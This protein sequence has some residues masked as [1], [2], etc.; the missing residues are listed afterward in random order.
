MAVLVKTAATLQVA[1]EST[2]GTFVAP[3]TTDS[4]LVEDPDF[5]VDLTTLERNFVR[6]SIS[7]TAIINGRKIARMKFSME[8]RSNGKNTGLLADAPLISRLFRACGFALTASATATAKIFQVGDHANPA[9]ALAVSAASATNTT[10]IMYVLRCTVG[11]ASATAQIQV[12]SDTAGESMA[13]ATITSGTP[14]T[15]GT[16][17]ATATI[18]FSGSLV[19][20][21]EWVVYLFP[22]GL[23]LNPISANFESVSLLMNKGGVQHQMPGCYGTFDI[24]AEAG[25][26]AK[27]NFDF[28]GI[29]VAPTDVAV[30]T[31]LTYETTLPAMVELAQLRVDDFNAI[32]SKY[33]LDIANEI[34]PRPDVSSAN[35]YIGLRLVDRKPEGG[36]D[37]EA[38]LVAQHDF[39]GKLSA[40]TR[41][42]FTIRCGTVVG[43]I[44]TIIHPQVQ[45]SGLTY[46]DRNN[47]LNYD[48]GLRIS[49]AAGDDE[50]LIF[51]G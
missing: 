38:D 24:E 18:T 4:L 49:S 37:P 48:A 3:G 34:Q 39:W 35:G 16:K 28:Q 43:N 36:I 7:P 44:V 32:V 22:K 25:Q 33:T 5:S 29:Y 50:V 40:A 9:T 47:I 6:A 30:P 31:N 51:F 12:F 15:L 42:P 8:L 46:Q 45:Y 26:Y 21:Q 14:K 23:L 27:V 17:G 19:V 2:Y 20:G 13:A 1:M 11:G 41:M 10:A